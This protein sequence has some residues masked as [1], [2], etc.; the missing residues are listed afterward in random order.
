MYKDIVVGYAV[1]AG[2]TR[3]NHYLEIKV[4]V[5]IANSLCKIAT[6]KKNV[7]LQDAVF[8]D[9]PLVKTS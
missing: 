5:E 7:N 3:R 8:G 9:V 6:T 2:I 1:S 4:N